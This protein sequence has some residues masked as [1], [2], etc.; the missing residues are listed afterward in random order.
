[1]LHAQWVFD[2]DAPLDA[3][4]RRMRAALER[5][6]WITGQAQVY[7]FWAQ[8]PGVRAFVHLEHHDWGV[9]VTA[10]VKPGWLVGTESHRKALWEAAREAQ[11]ASGSL[12]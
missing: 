1:L 6:G 9:Q 11:V 7:D 10:K 3:F 8:R 2:C 12:G 4:E 5:N